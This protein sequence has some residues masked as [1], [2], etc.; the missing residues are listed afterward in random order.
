M[1]ILHS[2]LSDNPGLSKC[3]YLNK[4]LSAQLELHHFSDRIK[5]KPSQRANR[6]KGK[7]NPKANCKNGSL[8]SV[9]ILMRIIHIKHIE[10]I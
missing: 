9:D 3:G 2:I 4:L 6:S 1:F 7:Y 8:A 5:N 10:T